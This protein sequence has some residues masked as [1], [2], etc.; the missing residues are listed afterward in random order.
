MV[1]AGI[2]GL[3]TARELLRRRPRL[4]LAVLERETRI[5][6][7]QSGHNSGVIH[8]G[9]YYAPGSLKA[10]LCVAG[11]R[12]LY[13][14]CEERGIPTERCG[15]VI[16]ATELE[17]LGRLDAL[18]R[19]GQENGVRGLEVV[20]PERLREL[21]PHCRGIRAIYSPDT[22]IVD[23][24]R[25]THSYAADVR[26]A[27]GEIHTGRPLTALHV[28][29]GEVVVETPVGEVRTRTLITCAGLQADRVA[30]LGGGAVEPR[31]VPFRGDYWQL[32]EGSRSLVRNLIYPVPDPAFPFLGVHATRRIGTGERWLGPNAVLAFAREG[33][34]RLTLRPRDLGAALGAPGFRRLAL[35][36]WQMGALEMWRDVSKRAFW[37][38]V[39]RY[40]PDIRLDDMV[41]GPS[42]VRAQALDESGT[43]VDDFVVDVQGSRVLHV[44]NAPSPAAT[45]SL[46]I[47]RLIADRATQ[48]FGEAVADRNGVTLPAR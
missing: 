19:R 37:Q 8:S 14:Y 15:K 18:Y 33:Y 23:H 2:V 47:G 41:P 29:P 11:S 46:A 10:R 27:G 40:L 31:V 39:R 21:E 30:R 45:S 1:G 3:A 13:A 43:L 20:G 34:G 38:S 6:A 7:H 26:N 48:V 12:E 44:R 42:G 22:G 35:R 5:A 28:R 24:A 25:V 16:V 4:R 9:I 32:A 17:E 36:Y